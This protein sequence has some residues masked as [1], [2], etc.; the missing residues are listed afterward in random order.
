MKTFTDSA[1]AELRN[2][3]PEYLE[4]RGMELRRSGSRLV[5]RCPF[6]E[7]AHPSFAAFRVTSGEWRCGCHPCGFTADV[8]E[9]AKRLGEGS[10]FP[11]LV[12]HVAA[13]LGEAPPVQESGRSAAP[14]PRR[15]RKPYVVPPPPSEAFERAATAARARL[16]NSAELCARV[17]E[18]L[19]VKEATVRSLCY[20]S[21][22]LGWDAKRERPLYLYEH[23]AKV[24]CPAG[25]KPRF[26]WL[27]GR[28]QAPWRWH[29]AARPEVA[30]VYLTEGESD[31]VALIDA[32]LEELCGSPPSAVVACPGTNFPEAWAPLFEGKRTT[33]VFDMDE[34]G[35]AAAERVA[36]L[37]E[38]H[39]RAVLV[40]GGKVAA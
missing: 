23:G 2:R 37:L 29:F 26:L 34:A 31:A 15:E 24:R 33:V 25:S 39:A 35:R 6:H 3:L 8:F 22:G 12:G 7:D 19:G 38:P 36:S 5:T 17:A 13:V 28:A 21:D 30:R 20:T 11:E 4:R 32:G 18:E 16:W 14:A 1:L 27:H 9:L 40:A 10:T